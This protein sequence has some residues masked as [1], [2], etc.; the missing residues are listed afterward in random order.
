MR[1]WIK[2]AFYARQMHRAF[3]AINT[4]GAGWLVAV[5]VSMQKVLSRFIAR[6]EVIMNKL[7]LVG[8]VG[9]ALLTMSASAFAEVGERHG[10]VLSADHMA[11]F[12]YYINNY[13]TPGQDTKHKGTNVTLLWANPNNDTSIPVP[14]TIPRISA[15]GFVIQSLSLGGSIGYYSV[16]GE[17]KSGDV[18]QDF[19]T[20]SGFAFAPRVGWVFDLPKAWSIWLRGGPSF[21]FGSAS[22][23]NSDADLWFMQFDVDCMFN[24]HITQSFGFNMGPTIAIP[25]TGSLDLGSTKVDA[26]SFSTGITLGLFGVL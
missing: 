24:F 12:A 23:E 3:P 10:F 7:L 6:G 18:S 9:A 8:A 2:V 13:D 25:I 15:D 19:P 20:L 5:D 21:F 1:V 4:H 11:G 14:G 22:R 16:A 17:A 26:T